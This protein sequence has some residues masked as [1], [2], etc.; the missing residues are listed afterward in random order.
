VLYTRTKLCDIWSNSQR[1]IQLAA[2]IGLKS[3]LVLVC[4]P[5]QHSRIW[6]VLLR[7]QTNIVLN[8]ENSAVGVVLNGLE[9]QE[10]I[11]LDRTDSVRLQ[12][13]VVIR[14]QLSRHADV[15]WMSDHHVDVGGAVGVSAHYAEQISRGAGGVNGV[16][17]R[18]QAVEP[19]F[20]GLV[21]AE[22]APKVVAGLVLGVEDVVLAVGAGLPHV[23][24]GAR[25]GLAGFGVLDDTVEKCELPVFRHVLDYAAAKVPEW[26]FGGPERSENG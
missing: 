25:D 17:G 11:V 15:V 16:F 1:N 24:D 9:V 4:V 23:E 2:V 26:C 12:P 8:I 6:L 3:E 21:G 18:L 10:Q 22:L 20:A 5:H 7:E 14:V 13:R 19:E